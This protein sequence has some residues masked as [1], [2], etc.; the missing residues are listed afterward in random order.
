MSDKFTPIH[1]EVL[2]ALMIKRLSTYEWQTLL[3]IIRKTYGYID[4]NGD[5]KRIDWITN[6]QISDMTKISRPHV[7]RAINKLIKKRFLKKEGIQ[8][9]L[10]KDFYKLPKQ[11]TELPKQVMEL[12]EQVTI[13]ER[14]TQT[15]NYRE[16][17]KQVLTDTQTGN[18]SLP[19]QVHTKEI[20]ENT[21]KETIMSYFNE[22]CKKTLK[23]SPL[24][25]KIIDNCLKGGR[26]VDDI[27]KAILNFSRDTWEDRAKYCDLV[28]AI[29]VRNK[30]D[31]FDKWFNLSKQIS[32]EKTPEQ[33]KKERDEY[34]KLFPQHRSY[35]ENKEKQEAQ[36]K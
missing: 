14:I 7:S 21:T 5:R 29:G 36:C 34:L 23:L 28:Y 30:I 8:I 1:N 4:D 11:A 13:R 19:K 12:P 31:N 35:I 27:K 20:K 9:G 2:E 16:L 32:Q 18:K 26:S 3:C 25:R 15:G 17:P 24:R 6:S 33:K 22:V 10:S